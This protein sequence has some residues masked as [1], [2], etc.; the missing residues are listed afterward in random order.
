MAAVT[1]Y[2]EAMR[3][4]EWRGVPVHLREGLARYIADRI[5]PGG[6]LM[7]AL[8]NDFLNAMLLASDNS[9]AGLFELAMFLHNDAPAEAVGDP[10]RVEAWLNGRFLA[11]TAGRPDGWVEWVCPACPNRD[12]APLSE[13][14]PPCSAEC[15]DPPPR[16]VRE[17]V[18]KA[19]SR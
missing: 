18:A 6:F 3:A 1:T 4:M 7:A 16:M 2:D 8:R 10:G 14:G 19:A 17:C 13:V 11:A 12:E 9:R 5:E 15:A